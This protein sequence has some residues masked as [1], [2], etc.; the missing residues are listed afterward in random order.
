MKYVDKAIGKTEARIKW[1]K[2]F[3]KI[4]DTYQCCDQIMNFENQIII[5]KL[6]KKL[7][8]GI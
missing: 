1:L 4:N 2:S 6:L 7:L 5:L 3:Q 8:E